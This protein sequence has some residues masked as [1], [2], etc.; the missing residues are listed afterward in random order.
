MCFNYLHCT[1]ATFFTRGA[2]DNWQLL[3]IAA[4][5]GHNGVNVL[6]KHYAK[7]QGKHLAKYS[8]EPAIIIK[9]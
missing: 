6:R 8:M 5:T 3:D 9:S 4:Q 1:R 7:M 2:E